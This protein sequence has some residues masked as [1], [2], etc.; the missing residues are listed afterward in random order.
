MSRHQAVDCG[1]VREI[2]VSRNAEFPRAPGNAAKPT[3]LWCRSCA[4]TGGDVDYLNQANPNES[5][6]QSLRLLVR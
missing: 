6:L 4:L 2:V 5:S 3:N 1:A